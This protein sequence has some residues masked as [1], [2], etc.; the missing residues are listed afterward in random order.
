MDQVRLLVKW[1]HRNLKPP[2]ISIAAPLINRE[3]Y[4][5]PP[6]LSLTTSYPIRGFNPGLIWNVWCWKKPASQAASVERETSNVSGQQPIHGRITLTGFSFHIYRLT[7]RVAPVAFCV[8]DSSTCNFIWFL[9]MPFLNFY[10]T[11][12]SIIPGATKPNFIIYGTLLLTTWPFVWQPL[13]VNLQQLWPKVL[14][15]HYICFMPNIIFF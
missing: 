3:L 12:K 9:C 4:S 8:S 5:P 11:N 10:T 15:K 2:T 14:H 6:T 7:S 13:M 1:M